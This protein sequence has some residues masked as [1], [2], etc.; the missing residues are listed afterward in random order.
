MRSEFQDSA[1]VALTLPDGS[2]Y[3]E[4]GVLEFAD[5]TVDA[6][7]GSHGARAFPNPQRKLLPGMFVRA[8]LEA[9]VKQ[10]ALLAR[11]KALSARPMV[12]PAFGW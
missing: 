3:P 6:N 4:T 8:K 11:S 12:T 1:P 5:L 2:T 10:D 9:G 7:T